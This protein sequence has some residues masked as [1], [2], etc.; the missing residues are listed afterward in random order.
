MLC[1]SARRCAESGVKLLY[2]NHNWEFSD[3]EGRVMQDLL[4]TACDELALCPDLG[5][6]HKGGEDVL[7]FLKQNQERI[8]AVHFKDFA[9]M[10]PVVDTVVLGRGIA[11]LREALAWLQTNRPEL[12]LIAEQD[13]CEGDPA[14]AVAANAAFLCGV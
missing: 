3:E 5:W 8:G 1:R 9:S 4:A 13:Y 6:I 11:P 7:E 14:D 10:E 2:H 12:W